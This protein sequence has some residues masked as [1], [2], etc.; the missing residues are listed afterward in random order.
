MRK[1]VASTRSRRPHSRIGKLPDVPIARAAGIARE[2][3]RERVFFNHGGKYSVRRRGAANVSEAHEQDFHAHRLRADFA[4]RKPKHTVP[5][6][7]KNPPAG[8]ICLFF[9]EKSTYPKNMFIA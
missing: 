9:G 8:R 3:S 1:T 4:G 7:L 2:R 5:A 6:T